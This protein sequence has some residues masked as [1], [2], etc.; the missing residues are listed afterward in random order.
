MRKGFFLRYV[1]AQH[2]LQFLVEH[3]DER[4]DI[5]FQL[6]HAGVCIGHAAAAFPLK[7]LGYHAH[8][9]D[10]HFAC[11]ARNH[12]RCAG[13][14]AAAHACGDEDHVRAVQRAAD[15]I[16]GSFGCVAAFVGLAARAQTGGA[17][18]DGVV[19]AAAS[20][21]LRVGVG[22]DEFHAID[23]AVDH[24]LYGVAAAAAYTHHFDAGARVEVFVFDHFDWHI[25]LLA[26]IEKLF[27]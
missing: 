24:V 15:F 1:V 19:C 10:A 7:R 6:G 11:H 4:I 3:H 5:G 26:I 14:G 17:Q 8:G 12:G 20:Q 21:R 9:K 22:A 13:A 2:F 27:R 23:L 16:H 18:L 25:S